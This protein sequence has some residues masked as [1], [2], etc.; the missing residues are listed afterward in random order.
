MKTILKHTKK[1]RGLDPESKLKLKMLY[2]LE[3]VTKQQ[4]SIVVRSIH[5]LRKYVNISSS[6]SQLIGIL[7]GILIGLLV[8]NIA[9]N[10]YLTITVILISFLAILYSEKKQKK[11]EKELNKEENEFA[12]L[13]E[14]NTETLSKEID[15][16]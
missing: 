14:K 5:N 12:K 7:S 8:S 1:S 10:I 3:N 2:F 6:S 13:L 15:T 9:N 16:L 4:S 11:F